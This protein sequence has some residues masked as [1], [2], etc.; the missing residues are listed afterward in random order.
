M[1]TMKTCS[2]DWLVTINGIQVP[3]VS[4]TVRYA[5]NSFSQCSCMVPYH[6]DLFKLPYGSI[7]RVEA[8]HGGICGA[9]WE[10]VINDISA[11]SDTEG[12]I[13]AISAV[14]FWGYAA[15]LVM[16]PT[17]IYLNLG[18]KD[19]ERLRPAD[20]WARFHKALTKTYFPGD[21]GGYKQTT[22]TD[23][24]ELIQHLEPYFKNNIRF[25]IAATAVFEAVFGSGKLLN[26][27]VL[28]DSFM[29]QKNFWQG[30]MM[31]SG[32]CGFWVLINDLAFA[33]TRDSDQR[34]YSAIDI[35]T[36][37]YN[38]YEGNG[39]VID[40]ALRRKNML[41]YTRYRIPLSSKYVTGSWAIG[42]HVLPEET[43]DGLMDMPDAERFGFDVWAPSPGSSYHSAS[44]KVEKRIGVRPYH[45]DGVLPQ[46]GSLIQHDQISDTGYMRGVMREIAP[47]VRLLDVNFYLQNTAANTMTF[48][49]LF[50]PYSRV[51]YKCTL[52]KTSESQEISSK[53]VH[54]FGIVSGVQHN[55]GAVMSSTISVSNYVPYSDRKTADSCAIKG[56]QIGESGIIF[57][58][59]FDDFYPL[60]AYAEREQHLVESI[61][62]S[63]RKS[64]NL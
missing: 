37:G 64:I 32:A 8:W 17:E 7:V 22:V 46:A 50:A 45:I 28:A 29:R 15:N 25:S 44:T 61:F 63:V 21:K 60:P 19:I 56:G 18:L 35:T 16:I 11:S 31:L 33:C 1:E 20:V 36:P 27:Q 24:P 58:P 40:R 51:G 12:D 38:Y 57:T 10:G 42:P 49:Y 43:Q 39:F 2:Q 34:V 52:Y 13:A 30:I 54:G 5:I 41:P 47:Y 9:L 62:N 14:D 6:E 3:A 53:S 59:L 23:P 48:D 26:S 55:L 4:A